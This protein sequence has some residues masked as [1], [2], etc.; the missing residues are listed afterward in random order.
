MPEGGSACGSGFPVTL[1]T[2]KVRG[3]ANAIRLRFESEQG[4]DFDLL[5]WAIVFTGG[6]SV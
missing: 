3:L 4:K 1:S 2:H 5:G 6:T